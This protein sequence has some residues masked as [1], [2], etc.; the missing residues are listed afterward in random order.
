M[1]QAEV[2]LYEELEEI[3]DIEETKES[4]ETLKEFQNTL[5]EKVL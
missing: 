5:K 2:E 3:I 1:S 4:I